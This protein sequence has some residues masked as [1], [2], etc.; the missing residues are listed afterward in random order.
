MNPVNYTHPC[1]LRF[2]TERLMSFDEKTSHD[3][4][5]VC[6]WLPNSAQ[7]PMAFAGWYCG[8]PDY[9]NTKLTANHYVNRLS[10]GMI[11]N[12]IE[13]QDLPEEFK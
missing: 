3:I 13:C 10:Y 7:D 5:V 11:E 9:E 6:V 8:E 4:S 12:L 1:G 2:T